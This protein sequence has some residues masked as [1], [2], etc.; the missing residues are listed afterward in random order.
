MNMIIGEGVIFNRFIDYSLQSKYF[1]IAGTVNDP[2]I[3]DEA[4][5]LQEEA[6]IA[7]AL[8]DHNDL[9][10]IYFSSCSLLD[11]SVQHTQ[12]VRHKIRMEK[13]IQKSAPHYYIFRLPEIIGLSE[14]TSNMVGS[15]VDAIIN[16]QKIEIWQN[17]R[18]NLIDI[19]DV[20]EV[21][22]EIL[23]RKIFHNKIIN[24]AS[25][26][27]TDL[28]HLV[29]DIEDFIG[30]VAN[31][32]LVGKGSE[33]H[34][35]ISDIQSILF[36]LKLDF[37]KNYVSRSLRKYFQHLRSTPKRLSIIVPTY[38]EERGIE[39]FYRRMNYVLE[40]LRPRFDYELIFVNDGSSDKTLAILNSIAINNTAVKLIDFSR[41]FGNQI[42]ITAG[43]DF[44][45]GDASIIIDD[46][47]QDPPEIILNLIAKWERG[48]K[49]VY[50]VRP[51]R[52]GVNPFFG[53]IAKLYYRIIGSLSDTNIPVDTGD[54]RLIDR[55]VLD[56][57]KAMREESRYYR[58]LVSW[59]GFPQIGVV[60]DRDKRFAG[61][62]TFSLK[63][64]VNFAINGLTS[65]TEK[66]LFFSS[67]A[68]LAITLISFIFALILIVNKIIDPEFSIQG[69]TSLVIISLFF[70]G[71]QLL[72]IGIL[73]VY[74]GKIYRQ[75]K[76]RPLYIVSSMKNVEEQNDA[77]H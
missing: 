21:V 39:E 63:K 62:S 70:G 46:D 32:I 64:Y 24:I 12:Y 54:F 72:S 47:L 53:V 9:T 18:R 56:S 49:V 60:Y 31:Y 14:T 76:G 50:G 55:V 77:Y 38:N 2:L 10:I 37:D 52:K 59:V 40:L 5:I 3:S 34:I 67:L 61:I 73:G 13:L 57:L 74:I 35:D 65:F 11:P 19:D 42:A 22:S 6:V 71:I 30:C 1:I 48:Y 15:Y 4:L 41:N 29:Q 23:R 26:Q 7:A 16:H 66:P 69:W 68:G 36:E 28:L 51:K 58:G 20:H 25:P 27:Q 8:S 45:C 75:V 33:Y 44:S 43:I 17:A